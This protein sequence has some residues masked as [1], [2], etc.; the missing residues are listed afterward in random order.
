M[1]KKS[2]YSKN[3][4]HTFIAFVS[5]DGKVDTMYIYSCGLQISTM[6]EK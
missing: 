4:E 1:E 6:N 5:H 2:E 3:Y